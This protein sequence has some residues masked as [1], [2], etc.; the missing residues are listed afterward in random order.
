M[1]SVRLILG[2]WVGIGGAAGR[3]VFAA[4]EAPPPKAPTTVAV[5]AK[6]VEHDD[7]LDGGKEAPKAKKPDPAAE[8]FWAAMKLL[9]SKAPAELAAGRAELEA[10]AAME[11]TPAQLVLGEYLQAGAAG[12]AKNPKKGTANFRLAAERGNGF[13]M[14]SY[15]L[16]LFSGI[17]VRKDA[18]KAEEWLNAALGPKAD[19]AQPKPPEDFS[20]A[21][22]DAPEE[23]LAGVVEVDPVAAAQAKA[24]YLLGVMLDGKKRTAEAQAHYVAATTAG[25]GKAGLQPAAVQAAVNYAFGRGGPRDAAKA[26]EMLRQAKTLARLSGISTLHNY[27]AA[28][29]VDDFAVAEIEEAIANQTEGMEGELQLN[30]A[31]QFTDKNSKDYDPKA[32]AMWFE[33]AAE[34]GQ[35]WAMLEL[36]ALESGSDLGAPQPEKAYGWFERAGGGDKPKHYLGTANLVICRLRGIGTTKDEAGALALAKQHRADELVCHLAMIGQCPER[37]VTFAEWVELNRKWAKEKKDAHAQYL[38]ARRY[39]NGWGVPVKFDEARNWLEKAVK[40]GSPAACRELGFL[41]ESQWSRFSREPR[42]AFRKAA[43]LYQRGAEG[44]DAIAT[45]NLAYMVN[46]GRG[47]L[48]A[49]EARAERLYQQCLEIDPTFARAQ[50]NLG[51]IYERRWRVAVKENDANLAQ[52]NRARMLEWYEK[53]DRAEFEYASNNLGRL[54][55]DGSLGEKDLRKAY[56]YFERAAEHGLV[57]ARFRLGEMHEKGEGV[58][59]TYAEAAYHYRLAALDG[60]LPALKRLVSFYIDGRSGAQDFERALFWL[61]QLSRRG[62]TLALPRMVDVMLQQGDYSNAIESLNLLRDSRNEE[63]EGFAYERLSRCYQDGLGVKANPGKAKKYLMMAFDLKNADAIARVAQ[64]RIAEGKPKEGIALFEQAGTNS[65]LATY[66]LGQMNYAGEFMPKDVAN[67]VQLFR[68]AAGKRHPGAMYFLAMMTLN[69]ETQAP[70]LE[71]AIEFARR[72]EALGHPKAGE[73][74]EKLE[75]RRRAVQ[76]DAGQKTENRSN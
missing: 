44:H 6:A 1:K 45:A 3:V 12:F 25:G 47:G 70:S 21:P 31:H 61:A 40:G 60:H 10:A 74:R 42:E 64:M 32:A 18:E 20:A 33:M 19:F 26:N 56:T 29:L 43:E 68:S 23:G 65:T 72:A 38:L 28:K 57:E 50:N 22:P 55:Y 8:K 37:P 39:M 41:Y 46:L 76:E 15:G 27:A 24:H 63:L 58:E 4:G 9:K 48:A 17:G 69:K 49:D 66:S 14:V 13:A 67:A 34:S 54:Y 2:F 52:H 35:A 59:V 7:E 75:E 11:F 30:I 71:E 5:K 16:C 53:A 36:A 62:D 51:S 73:L